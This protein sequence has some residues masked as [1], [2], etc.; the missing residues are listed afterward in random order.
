[1]NYRYVKIG[2][3]LGGVDEFSLYDIM[4]ERFI[5][6]NDVQTWVSIEDLHSDYLAEGGLLAF[7]KFKKFIQ[8][9]KNKKHNNRS[10]A[11]SIRRKSKDI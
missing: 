10:N 2:R 9:L 7:K 4:K 5:T 3:Q 8:E 6:F 1:M 11:N